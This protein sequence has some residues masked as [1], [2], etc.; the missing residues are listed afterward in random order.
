MLLFFSIK[1]AGRMEGSSD[2][3]S[4]GGGGEGKWSMA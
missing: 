1:M 3:K 2:A 4:G